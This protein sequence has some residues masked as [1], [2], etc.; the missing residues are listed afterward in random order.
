VYN[1]DLN[2][3]GAFNNDLMYIPANTSEM[4]FEQF[5]SGGRTYTAAQQAAAFEAYIKQD[6]YLS[7]RRGQY[8]ERN[9][10]KLP[11]LWRADLSVTQDLF[12]T[13]RGKL[14]N[15]QVRVDM[16]NFTNFLNN[17]WGASQRL[18]APNGRPLSTAGVDANGAARFRMNSVTTGGDLVAKTFNTNAGVGDVW[19]FQ[20]GLTTRLTELAG[21]N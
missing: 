9:G 20:L 3:E 12:T 18:E 13:V 7:T 11:M 6:P 10:L 21:R 15:L 2:G 19:R 14:N 8:A 5:T 4:V 17:N 16:L 1:G